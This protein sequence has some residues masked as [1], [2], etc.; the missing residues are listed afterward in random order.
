MHRPKLIRKRL[1]NFTTHFKIHCTRKET[2]MIGDF[3]AKLGINLR[4]GGMNSVGHFCTGENTNRNG[5]FLQNFAENNNLKIANT[6]FRKKMSKKWT[7]VSP[8]MSQKTKLIS[9]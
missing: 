7:W 9:I 1:K 4:N 8:D 2:I 3:N 6:F 5:E